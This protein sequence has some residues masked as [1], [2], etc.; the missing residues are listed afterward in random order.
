MYAFYLDDMRLPVPPPSLELKI[1]NQNKTVTLIHEGEVNIV[2]RPGLSEI[3]FKMPIPQT[4]V[5]YAGG[6]RSADYYLGK[7][8][9][10]KTEKKPFQFICSRALPSGKLLFDTNITVALEEYTIAEDAEDGFDLT[11]AITLRQYVPYG[12]K[13]QKIMPAATGSTGTATVQTTTQR[14]AQSAP[15]VKTYTV[16][17]GDCLWNIAKKFLGDG[18]K[19]MEIYRLNKDKIKNPNLIYAGQ[20]LTLP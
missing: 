7:L 16:V 12:T 19:Y 6:L 11:L 2:K 18:S 14:P 5:P 13:T 3:S 10:L 1:K 8:E 20:V 17:K 4:P 15:K 9:Q